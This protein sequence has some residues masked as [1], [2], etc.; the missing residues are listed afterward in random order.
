MIEASTM[1]VASLAFMAIG[2]SV[3]TCASTL[4][5]LDRQ[6]R[7]R[8]RGRA[9]THDVQVL[10]EEIVEAGA[11]MR[12]PQ[13]VADVFGASLVLSKTATSFAAGCGR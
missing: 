12:D 5:G 13:P 10:I 8:P 4:H 7:M 1:L 3:N 11:S 2:F 9:D 6:L